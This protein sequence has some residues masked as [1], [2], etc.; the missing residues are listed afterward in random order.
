MS[1]TGESDE[2]GGGPQ[3]V[4]VPIIDLMTGM[5]AAVAVLGG[6]VGRA[7]TGKGDHIDVAMLDV[8]VAMLANQ[9]MNYLVS[10]KDPVRRGNRHPNIQPQDVF[11]VRDGHIV[12]AV[13]NDE[14]FRRFA[15]AVGNPELASDERYA[16]NAARVQNLTA[17]TRWSARC[18]C[19]AT[20]MTGWRGWRNS[21][22]PA[23]RSTR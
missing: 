6:L 11:A 5:Y 21:A 3:K 18:C 1:V 10:Q 2:R 20:S 15:E 4:G 19:S 9:A 22:F 14:Q 16:T 17:C 7:K 8:S 13:G 12:L 23:D